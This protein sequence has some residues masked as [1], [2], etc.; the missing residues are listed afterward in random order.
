MCKKVV[1]HNLFDIAYG[2]EQQR[3]SVIYIKPQLKPNSVAFFY[4][5][6]MFK[7]ILRSLFV[8]MSWT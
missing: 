1:C 3:E 4:K 8:T 5:Y 7:F 2:I 6:I